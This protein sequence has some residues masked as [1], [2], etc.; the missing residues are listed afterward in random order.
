MLLSYKLLLSLILFA[1]GCSVPKPRPEILS[2]DPNSS[3]IAIVMGEG[4]SRSFAHIGVM[5]ALEE[6]EIPVHLIIGSGTGALMAALYANKK[7]AN[8]MEWHAMQLKKSAYL[9]FKIDSFL[10]Q[11]LTHADIQNLPIPL[12]LVT[13]DLKTGKQIILDQGSIS[14]AVQGAMI[15][16]GLSNPIEYNGNL[17]VSGEIA[18]GIPVDVAIQKGADLIIAIDLMEGI[19]NYAF[20]KKEDIA[21]QT[22][23]I[24][25]GALSK[26][27]LEQ[28]HIVIRPA[29]SNIDFLDFSRKR[30]ALLFGYEAMR[31]EIPELKKILNIQEEE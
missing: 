17:L 29:V 23:K 28:A 5:K 1:L 27:Q 22:Y 26:K 25:S 15:I 2:L 16:P 13:T 11:R 24:S 19:E 4:L 31:K 18:T 8:D 20:R 6:E 12:T 9:D 7:S 14:K 30:E 21:I 10:N 3:V